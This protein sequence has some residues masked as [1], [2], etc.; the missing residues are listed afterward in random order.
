[1]TGSRSAAELS[2]SDDRRSSYSATRSPPVVVLSNAVATF[3]EME[4]LPLPPD[5]ER[6]ISVHPFPRRTTA[7]RQSADRSANMMAVSGIS[8]A[9]SV[10]GV[11]RGST[12]SRG[13]IRRINGDGRRHCVCR[14][15]VGGHTAVTALWR[16]VYECAVPCSVRRIIGPLCRN[17]KVDDSPNVRPHERKGDMVNRSAF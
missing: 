14:V 8:L 12:R 2:E 13:H 4:R 15:N 3:D 16:A 11:S 17:C 6:H 1:M 10:D 9:P 7:N 5:R